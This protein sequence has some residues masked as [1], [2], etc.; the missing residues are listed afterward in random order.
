MVQLREEA[1]KVIGDTG[2]LDHLLKHLA[3]QVG[4]TR[5]GRGTGG[6]RWGWAPVGRRGR[7]GGIGVWGGARQ[8]RRLDRLLE[9]PGRRGGWEAGRG[10]VS[11]VALRGV[12]V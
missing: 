1:R 8:S 10:R 2:L 12:G 4:G 3:D 5:G 9:V 7:G 6:L 11:G